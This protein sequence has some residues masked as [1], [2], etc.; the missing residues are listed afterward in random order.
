[1]DVVTKGAA[2]LDQHFGDK[3]WR[4]R[5]DLENLDMGSP[6][7]CILG[8]LFQSYGAG[9]QALKYWTEPQ[10]TQNNGFN[11][12][13]MHAGKHYGYDSLRSAWIEELS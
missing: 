5:I 6:Y 1:M 2:L 13:F 8:Q 4:K 10:F 11:A 12:P 3:E 7:W 9:L